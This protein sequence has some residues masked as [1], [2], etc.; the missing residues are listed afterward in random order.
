L[1]RNLGSRQG[2]AINSFDWN[3]FQNIAVLKEKKVEAKT[4]NYSLSIKFSG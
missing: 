4:P 1:N 3:S 2:E